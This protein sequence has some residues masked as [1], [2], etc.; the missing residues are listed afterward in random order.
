V[1]LNI[2]LRPLCVYLNNTPDAALRE[3]YRFFSFMIPPAVK[4]STAPRI[5]GFFLIKFS[6][7]SKRVVRRPFQALWIRGAYTAHAA[8]SSE[9]LLG[10]LPR[11][12]GPP[13]HDEPFVIIS[14]RKASPTRAL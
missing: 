2:L 4:V 14:E 9:L 7:F 5:Y 3:L 11:V 13:P 6:I 8:N 10:E 1:V 12:T